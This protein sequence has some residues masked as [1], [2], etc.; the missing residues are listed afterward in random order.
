VKVERELRI[1]L[2]CS[3]AE[4]AAALDSALTSGWERAPENEKGPLAEQKKILCYKRERPGKRIGL[5]LFGGG[6]ILVVGNVVSEE[7]DRAELSLA[8]HNEAIIDFHHN[9]LAHLPA[10]TAEIGLWSDNVNV[11]ELVT[12]EAWR[13]LRAFSDGAA[14]KHEWTT[15]PADRQRWIEF[16]VEWERTA[17]EHQRFTPKVLRRW[18]EDEGWVEVRVNELAREFDFAA[19]LLSVVRKCS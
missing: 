16:L 10:G 7:S 2:L 1:S 3:T 11:E 12:A 18:L 4:F 6:D 15:P 13:R 8:E 5:G 17:A 9:C 19:D 14:H